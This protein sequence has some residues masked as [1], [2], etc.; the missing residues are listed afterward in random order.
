MD[1]KLKTMSTTFAIRSNNPLKTTEVAYRFGL[2]GNKGVG[3]IWLTKRKLSGRTGV[4]P[5]DNTAQ[6]V[7]CVEDLRTLDKN[8]KL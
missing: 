4:F 2:G 8:G 1:L 5:L 7:V 3:I 6:G